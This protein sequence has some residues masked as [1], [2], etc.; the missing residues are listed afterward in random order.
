MVVII[1]MAFILPFRLISET[2]CLIFFFKFY[3][4]VGFQVSKL[5][6]FDHQSRCDYWPG[7]YFTFSITFQKLL[8]QFS[9][10]FASVLGFQVPLKLLNS[11]HWSGRDHRP[12]LILPFCLNLRNYLSNFFFQILQTCWVSGLQVIKFWSSI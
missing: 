10:N 2:T 6:N 12:G 9:S 8:V 7:P 1:D 3:K 11:D 5:I 4:L